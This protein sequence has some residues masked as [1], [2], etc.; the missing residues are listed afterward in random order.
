MFFFVL[1]AI[2]ITPDLGLVI[3]VV[4]GVLSGTEQQTLPANDISFWDQVIQTDQLLFSALGPLM[5]VRSSGGRM[6]LVTR[7]VHLWPPINTIR[8]TIGNSAAEQK[9]KFH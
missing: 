6:F 1:L 4:V 9:E 8:A 2:L 5:I 3:V 7:C